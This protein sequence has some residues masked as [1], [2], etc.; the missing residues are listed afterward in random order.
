MPPAFAS[1]FAP[2]SDGL[3]ADSFLRSRA[4]RPSTAST[5]L[6]TAIARTVIKLHLWSIS[7]GTCGNIGD[8]VAR[9]VNM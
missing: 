4:V 8:I 7:A 5:A 3:I 9:T 2:R 1:S 6:G